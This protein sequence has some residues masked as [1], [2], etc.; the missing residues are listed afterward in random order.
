MGRGDGR[1]MGKR[2]QGA[3]GAGEGG[4]EMGRPARPGM[5]AIGRYISPA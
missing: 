4:G 2:S 5:G 3:R 1:E